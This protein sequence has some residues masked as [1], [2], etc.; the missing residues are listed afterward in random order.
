MS[1]KDMKRGNYGVPDEPTMKLLKS[2][3]LPGLELLQDFDVTE[4]TITFKDGT[5]R[6]ICE[7][8]SRTMGYY[9]PVEFWNPGKQQEHR[10]RRLFREPRP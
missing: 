9:R 2:L 1:G 6:Q 3:D 10:D 5:T 4:R 8:F 7:R